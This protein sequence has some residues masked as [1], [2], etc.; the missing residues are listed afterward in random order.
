MRYLA[1]YATMTPERGLDLTKVLSKIGEVG[2]GSIYR[3]LDTC[4]GRIVAI[5]H[6]ADA[7]P[8]HCERETRAI[9]GLNHPHICQLTT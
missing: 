3:A 1:I 4:V 7:F 6:V 5:K 8:D 2:M 9:A